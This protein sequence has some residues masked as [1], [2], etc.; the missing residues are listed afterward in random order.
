MNKTKA[1]NRKSTKDFTLSL[2]AGIL[3]LSNSALLGVVAR[4]FLGIMPT[5][6]G[7]S[8]ND[9]M[10]FY[11]L[12]AIGIIFGVLVTFGA[13]MLRNKSANKKV[14]GAMI[15]AF[16]IPSVITG[17]GFIIGFLLGIIGG[18]ISLSGK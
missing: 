17:G 4:W 14:W 6:P 10:V 12:S 11:T 8:G 5:L 7:S 3:I 16:S 2:I 1:L 18:K 9:P 13:I 15:I